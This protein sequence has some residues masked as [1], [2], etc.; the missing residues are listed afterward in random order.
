MRHTLD[1]EADRMQ[2]TTHTPEREKDLAGDVL[3]TSTEKYSNKIA[4]G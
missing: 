1:A 3:E 2:V 4:F